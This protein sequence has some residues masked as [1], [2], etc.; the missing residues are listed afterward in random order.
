M[1]NRFSTITKVKQNL[2]VLNVQL[3]QLYHYISIVFRV[4]IAQFK[5]TSAHCKLVQFAA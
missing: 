4:V 3:Q 2:T 1:Q 5:I